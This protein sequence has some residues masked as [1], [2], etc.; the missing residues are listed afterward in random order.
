MA[1]EFLT[2][3][4]VDSTQDS[5]AVTVLTPIL[6][7]DPTFY[8][9]AA[10][11]V[12][13]NHRRGAKQEV[14]RIAKLAIATLPTDPTADG[15]D[16]A[17]ADLCLQ[18]MRVERHDLA[19]LVADA[20]LVAAPG[21]VRLRLRRVDLLRQLSREAESIEDLA[22]LCALTPRDADV[23]FNFGE[24][25][26]TERTD[27]A[28]GIR[29]VLPGLAESAMEDPRYHELNG[30]LLYLSGDIAGAADELAVAADGAPET[31]LCRYYEGLFRL[32]AGQPDAARKA[33][34][35]L[36]PKFEF[37]NRADWLAKLVSP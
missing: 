4:Y 15:S 37:R 7:R 24:V 36:P 20:G 30:Y 11:L 25:L 16:G 23:Q 12:Q 8:G 31:P 17:L 14:A 13:V 21:S 18:L 29:A 26:V 32:L 3:R 35:A 6:N 5:E 2:T 27:L 19:L 9:A 33:L 10:T 34:T 28:S 1:R 22:L